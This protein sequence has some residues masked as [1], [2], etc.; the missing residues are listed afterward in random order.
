MR[1]ISVL[2]LKGGV[3]KT[4]AA[5]NLAAAGAHAGARV[6]LVD[7]D[8]QNS[9]TDHVL[10]GPA[11]G[12]VAAVLGNESSIADAATRLWSLPGAGSLDLVA[13]GE[14]RLS[15]AE[16]ALQARGSKNRLRVVLDTLRRRKSGYDLVFVDT[17]PGLDFLWYNALYAADLVLCPIE[18]QMP[19][20]QG[21]RRFHELVAFAA[22]EDGLDPRVFYV[23]TNNDGRLRESRDLL[24]VLHEQ[25][26]LYPDGKTLP[27]IRY[28]SALSKAYGQRQSIFDF[29]PRDQAAED[30][31][32]LIHLILEMPD[33]KTK[34]T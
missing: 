32:R 8:P 31:A 6:M 30:C 28:S 20:L 1:V 17:G 3:G 13:S 23:P 11:A 26:G 9:A 4:T 18:L 27:A 16:S 33:G 5:V 14:F 10:A 12:D 25:Y 15:A 22:E 7:F 24:A 19:A 34:H 2:N 21:L 29:D